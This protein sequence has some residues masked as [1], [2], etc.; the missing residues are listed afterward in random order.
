MYFDPAMTTRPLPPGIIRDGPL[1]GSYLR[2]QG[3]DFTGGIEST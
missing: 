2:C 3:V 1:F